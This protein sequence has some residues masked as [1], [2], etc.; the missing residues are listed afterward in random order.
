MAATIN[1]IVKILYA[2]MTIAE[3]KK[4]HL[5]KMKKKGD[6]MKHGCAALSL[7]EYVGMKL[8][9][10]FLFSP[11]GAACITTVAPGIAAAS[12]FNVIIYYS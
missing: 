4:M 12:N 5:E 10:T 7:L 8:D 2:K 1:L 11:I 3:G 6:S 9:I